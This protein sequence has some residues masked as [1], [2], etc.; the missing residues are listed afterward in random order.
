[1]H[2]SKLINCLMLR[3][4]IHSRP[5]IITKAIWWACRPNSFH[6][7]YWSFSSAFILRWTSTYTGAFTFWSLVAIFNPGN[8]EFGLGNHDFILAKDFRMLRRNAKKFSF[9]IMA[10]VWMLVHPRQ[11]KHRNPISLSATCLAIF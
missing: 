8:V 1:V 7:C 6:L 9:F 2:F 5:T 10:P 4:Q 3:C 11:V